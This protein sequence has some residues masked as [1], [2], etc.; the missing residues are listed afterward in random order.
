MSSISGA[1]SPSSV[2]ASLEIFLSPL[3][4]S[5]SGIFGVLA[6]DGNSGNATSQ[7]LNAGALTPTQQN[8][9]AVLGGNGTTATAVPWN[10]NGTEPNVV[11]QV[12]GYG[13]IKLVGKT[14]D[15]TTHAQSG[16][17]V[18]T[19]VGQA[20]YNRTSGGRIGAAAST[21]LT[22]SNLTSS[23]LPSTGSAVNTLD[24]QLASSVSSISSFLSS[25]GISLTA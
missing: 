12:R 18:L 22:A 4:S 24:T 15:P 19:A 8:L 16:L 5:T 2:G 14:S 23:S 1:F 21:P 11:T 3:S 17:Y 7:A 10:T 20:I 9:I 25:V 13:W 6:G